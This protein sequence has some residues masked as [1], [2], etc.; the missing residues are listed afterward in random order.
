MCFSPAASFALAGALVPLGLYTVARVR[1]AAPAWIP[2]AAF[3]L[4][5][6]IQ[7]GVEGMVW[8]GLLG[9]RAE[10]SR[11]TARLYLLFSHFFW[12]AF[13]PVAIRQIETDPARRRRLGWLAAAGSVLGLLLYLPVMVYP[14][15]LRIGIVDHS[16]D[17]R[18]TL[19][20]GSALPDFAFRLAYAA[21][22]LGALWLSSDPRIRLF[23]TFIS[24]SLLLTWAAFA[25][26]F[27][28]VWCFFAALLSVHVAGIEAARRRV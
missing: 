12:P 18:T 3:P 27:V 1:H 20:Q 13:V 9:D 16:I 2:F 15:L 21:I 19:P 14:E 28:S 10:L 25:Y 26:A 5:F 6:G 11:A 24:V 23:G 17:Y 7:Q 8:L 22:I 4:A